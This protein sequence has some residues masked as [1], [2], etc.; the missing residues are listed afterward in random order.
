MLDNQ[1]LTNKVPKLRTAWRA[2]T[3]RIGKMPGL[4]CA[5]RIDM[6]DGNTNPASVPLNLSVASASTDP[7]GDAS[8]Y[9]S[10]LAPVV[11]AVTQDKII[12]LYVIVPVTLPSGLKGSAVAGTNN[13][14]GGLLRYYTGHAGFK[15]DILV[16]N[17][18][19]TEFGGV[20]NESIL[21]AT[22]SPTKAL[23]DF[24]AAV[25]SNTNAVDR[26]YGTNIGAYFRGVK[27][28]RKDRSV[29]RAKHR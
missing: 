5:A 9:M 13:S 16:P 23:N 22:G 7:I 11:D 29:R 24:L 28:V 6:I 18:L 4:N 21:A 27:S 20:N 8:A 12:G 10:S 25:A 19:P 14:V 1:G 2:A 26:I 15:Q 17:Y 3:E